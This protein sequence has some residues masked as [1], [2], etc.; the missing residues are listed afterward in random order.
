MEKL[1]FW[2]M[3]GFISWFVTGAIGAYGLD[4]AWEAVNVWVVMIGLLVFFLWLWRSLY[5]KMVA[6][7]N[8]EEEKAA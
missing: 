3:S 1:I 4:W 6:S 8:R 7:R 2:I 5:R